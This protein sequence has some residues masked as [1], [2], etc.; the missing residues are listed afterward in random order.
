MSQA[1]AVQ[2]RYP[3]AKT[4]ASADTIV[5]HRVPFPLARR[6]QQ[7]CATVLA[8][9]YV[10][11]E[12]RALEYTA[13]A[14]L[15][16]FPGIDQRQLARLTGVDRTNVGQIIDELEAKGLVERHVNG[17]DRRAR[18]LHATPPGK[19]L[20]RELRPKLLAA[21]A[22][23][24]EPLTQK[25]QCLL[26]DLLARVVEA[27]EIYAR[28]GAGRR[29]PRRKNAADSGGSDEQQHKP[30]PQRGRRGAPSRLSDDSNRR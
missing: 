21:Q 24:L 25:E 15:D 2:Q 10:G 4:A 23:M 8:E 22:R 1:A 27:N 7:I 13:L 5:P 18:E 6:F 26:I 20:R 29:P 11:E 19:K 17:D 14:C 16:D 30:S 28:P 3:W 9:V 12:L